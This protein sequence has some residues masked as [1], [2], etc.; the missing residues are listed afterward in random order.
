[1]QG[2]TGL[3]ARARYGFAVAT[4]G[5]DHAPL[6][7]LMQRRGAK[8]K[9]GDKARKSQK[10]EEK[11][12]DRE[13]EDLGAQLEMDRVEAEHTLQKC[14]THLK[15]TLDG[16]NTSSTMDAS[17]LDSVTIK[18][19]Y[20]KASGDKD[21]TSVPLNQLAQYFEKDGRTLQVI[22]YMPETLKAVEN[23]IRS[24]NLGLNPVQDTLNSNVLL[25]PI[26]TMGPQAVANALKRIAAA[27]QIALDALGN[28]H[29]RFNKVL[30]NA[31]DKPGVGRDT[32]RAYENAI[33]K[34]KE[35]VKKRIVELTDKKMKEAKEGDE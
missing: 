22:L 18:N 33:E 4:R 29:K 2:M 34:V 9:Q 13:S 6:W 15:A 30:K 11:K 24:A 31:K 20:G 27:K 12:A 28:E 10:A 32:L 19:P 35:S 8:K 14:V 5:A 3:L 1:M 21:G 25:I 26:P 7:S 17:L 16:I 23:G